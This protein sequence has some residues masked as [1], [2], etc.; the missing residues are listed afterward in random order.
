M[1]DNCN[2]QY[3]FQNISDFRTVDYITEFERNLKLFLDYSFL[4]IGAWVNVDT[5]DDKCIDMYTMTR[6]IPPTP[7]STA[8][9]NKIFVS[10][11]QNWVWESGIDFGGTYTIV[12]PSVYV[13]NVLAST[14]DYEIDYEGGRVIFDSAVSTTSEV[15]VDYSFREVQVY[16]FNDAFWW[17]QIENDVFSEGVEIEQNINRILGENRIQLPSIVIQTMPSIKT[18]PYALGSKAR[19]FYHDVDFIIV[20]RTNNMKNKLLS[21]LSQQHDLFITL[22]NSDDITDFPLN[23]SGKSDNPILY[24]TLVDTYPWKCTKV[25]NIVSADIELPCKDIYMAKVRMTFEIFNPSK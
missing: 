10:K 2:P 16:L 21:I 7:L 4:K 5:S 9:K 24:N 3:Q 1:S 17:K 15:T 23:C 20:A 18:M 6:Y 14:G 22:F 19:Y 8:Y 13:D 12:P 11:R 25:T